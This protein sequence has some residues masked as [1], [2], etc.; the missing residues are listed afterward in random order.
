MAIPV[1]NLSQLS[2][3][4]LKQLMKV[5]KLSWVNCIEKRDMVEA[6]EREK[7]RNIGITVK[8]PA[9]EL[10]IRIPRGTTLKALKLR[11]EALDN[12]P[13]R[14]QRISLGTSELLDTDSLLALGISDRSILKLTV[15][16]GQTPTHTPS[17][18]DGVP[19]TTWGEGKSQSGGFEKGSWVRITGL[20]K[21][22]FYNGML[23]VILS[24]GLNNGRYAVN[25]H[26]KNKRL[27]VKPE[28]LEAARAPV[29]SAEMKGNEKGNENKGGLS[30]KERRRRRFQE[31]F[32]NAFRLED[33]NA[34]VLFLERNNKRAIAKPAANAILALLRKIQRKPNDLRA[35]TL[36]TASIVYKKFIK[37][38]RGASEIMRLAGFQVVK[39]E[40]KGK[41]RM[42]VK[43]VNLKRLG[44]LI[45]A[46]KSSIKR[47][48]N[49]KPS[50]DEK[51]M[52][53]LK[54]TRKRSLET[55]GDVSGLRRIS[56]IFQ[57]LGDPS[58]K[59]SAEIPGIPGS[60]R[61]NS[62]T[63]TIEDLTTLVANVRDAVNRAIEA[64]KKQGQRLGNAKFGYYGEA[65]RVSVPKSG[66][67]S[68][69]PNGYG[70]EVDI[71]GQQH[72]GEFKKGKPNGYG[73]RVIKGI[74]ENQGY[75][76]NGQLEGLGIQCEGTSPG[77]T[78]YT[79]LFKH[80]SPHGIGVVRGPEG[81]KIEGQFR[82]GKTWGSGVL[83][84]RNM[85]Y[86]GEFKNGESEGL[87]ALENKST[88]G[89]VIATY[90]G[91]FRTGLPEGVGVQRSKEHAEEVYEGEFS[92]G[93]K[94]GYG[95]SKIL[96]DGGKSSGD[97][98]GYT[99]IG[100]FKNGR[101]EGLGSILFG[102]HV[103]SFRGKIFRTPVSA[104]S[105]RVKNEDFG[106]ADA[107]DGPGL[108]KAIEG[109]K[110]AQIEAL[111][112]QKEA[113]KSAAR[114]LL[115]AQNIA[116]KLIRKPHDAKQELP[117]REVEGERNGTTNGKKGSRRRK[118]CFFCGRKVGLEGFQCRCGNTYCEL[119]RLPFQHECTFDL[120][121]DYRKHLMKSNLKLRSDQGLRDRLDM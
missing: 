53:P 16:V 35:R 45:E 105:V 22:A 79:G 98:R 63:P 88:S 74:L 71:L 29:K 81:L 39:A 117:S 90:E 61:G 119:H 65:D 18:K 91:Q 113:Q 102:G 87:G 76:V 89:K 110:R 15:R 116:S 106:E 97:Q 43:K 8:T 64:K 52:L 100:E 33:P 26:T 13:A 80:G 95:V 44:E 11:I 78:C 46:L 96:N 57:N 41:D 66:Q 9:H 32:K 84:Q 62:K 48:K 59:V 93:V 73:K 25:V 12:L 92:K 70:V 1:E 24:Q 34:A 107:G 118:R 94:H 47:L 31:Q 38:V 17:R 108:E 21:A 5:A 82:D 112:K 60:P 101:P 30:I 83:E 19:K 7:S 28:N 42:E 68:I 99:Y 114:A 14:M 85:R 2:I 86:R 37:N 50:L 115:Q 77:E 49:S 104:M 55:L 67:P 56:G 109:G 51:S 20:K 121:K 111:E 120:S 54:L 75:F 27:N 36:P 10:S 4:Q 23:G 3:S 72:I 6:L 69:L 40:R 103:S 58:G